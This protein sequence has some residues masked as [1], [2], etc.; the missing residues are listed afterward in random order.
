[1]FLKNSALINKWNKEGL[2]SS[3]ITGDTATQLFTSGKAAYWVTGPWNIDT[4]RKAGIK[5][6]I[7]QVPK[8]KCNAVPFLGVQGLMVSRYAAGHGVATAAKDFVANYMAGAGPQFTLAQA[9]DRYPANTTAGKRVS[10]P[11]LKQIGLASKGGVPMP[12][13]PQMDSVWTRPRRRMGQVDQGRRRDER[14][15]S[16]SGPHPGTSRRRSP[17]ARQPLEY[18]HHT[19]APHTR[20]VCV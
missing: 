18:Q 14:R 20:G 12:N 19:N 1:M 15:A 7:V 4:A 17:E 10:D 16:P 2:I 6:R 8:I 5:F 3:K 9:N 11:A 13:I